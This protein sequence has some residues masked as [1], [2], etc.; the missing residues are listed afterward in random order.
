MIDPRAELI[1]MGLALIISTATTILLFFRLAKQSKIIKQLKEKCA[2]TLHHR[3]S[4]EVRLGHIGENLAPFLTGWPHNSNDF[5]FLGNPIDG[6]Q[7]NDN[8]IVFIEIKTGN[9]RLSKVQKNLK[10]I[11]KEGNV[12]FESFRIGEKGVTVKRDTKED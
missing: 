11:V 2:K 12:Y 10:R 9:A 5:R 6:V 8:E 7:F 1:A 3:K 4:S